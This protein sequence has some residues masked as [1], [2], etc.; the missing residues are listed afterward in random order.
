MFYQMYKTFFYLSSLVP[1]SVNNLSQY[2]FQSAD[3][4]QSIHIKTKA[5]SVLTVLSTFCY[6]GM[7]HFGRWSK[8]FQFPFSKII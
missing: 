5:W 8:T 3:K 1:Q 4:W 6:K 7:E 2:S